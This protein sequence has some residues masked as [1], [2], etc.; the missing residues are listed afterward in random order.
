MT[1][2]QI[3]DMVS[4]KSGID[5]SDWTFLFNNKGD[6]EFYKSDPSTSNIIQATFN[7]N[8]EYIYE[9]SERVKWN[10]QKTESNDRSTN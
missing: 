8:D 5:L 2:L 10:E 7:V 3:R 4:L 1:A 9:I 6:L